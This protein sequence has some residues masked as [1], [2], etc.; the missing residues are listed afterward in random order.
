M[1]LRF[2]DVKYKIDRTDWVVRLGDGSEIWLAGLDDKERTEK[3]LGQEY[4]VDPESK[5][6]TADLRWIPA[7]DVAVGTEIIGFPEELNGHQTLQR[8]VVERA[9]IIDA[10]KYR[11][12][13]DRGET[14]VSAQHRFVGGKPKTRRRL[15]WVEA[16]HLKVGSWI[17]F[18]TTP[19]GEPNDYAKVLHVE[20]IGRGPVVSFGTSTGTLIADGFL[21]HNCTLYFNECSQIAYSAVLMARTRLAQKTSLINR[22][23]Y[24]CNPPGSKHW[25]AMVFVG[26]KDPASRPA[27]A[28][29][30]NPNNFAA[31]VMNPEGNRQNLS[32]EYIAELETL[33]E[34][35]RNRFLLGKFTADL[36][37]ALWNIDSF[38]NKLHLSHDEAIKFAHERCERVVVSVDP[39]GASGEEDKRSDE[40]GI[41]V[42]GRTRDKKYVVLADATMRGSPA[43]WAR[44]SIGLYRDFKADA[45]VAEKNFGG[46]MVKH[47]IQS[48]YENAPVKE[49][50]AARGKAIRAEPISALYAKGLVQHVQGL[51]DLEDQMCNLTTAGYM[52]ERSPD[53]VDS[54]VWGL[55]DLSQGTNVQIIGMM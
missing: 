50:T 30:P 31:M 4:C 6:L 3:I 17:K 9:D 15:K 49:V 48:E 34:R 37:N 19:W 5:I 25:T 45:I 18:T 10:E 54:L 42:T 11:I 51:G 7:K 53:R 2:P 12:I 22:A 21:G 24:D 38:T 36:D 8:A 44:R 23:Y 40:I 47:T 41:T 27:G 14:I 29:L 26:K 39:S 46:A 28:P 20:R 16:Q 52:G 55:S 33:P 35:Q 1:K 43:Q 32:E 13:T